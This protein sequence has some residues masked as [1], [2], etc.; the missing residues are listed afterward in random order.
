MRS[1][2]GT[3]GNIEKDMEDD[4]EVPRHH[5]EVFEIFRYKCATAAAS[6]SR[7][8]EQLFSD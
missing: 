6:S 1:G 3:D 2:G 8:S 4:K 5:E 7:I